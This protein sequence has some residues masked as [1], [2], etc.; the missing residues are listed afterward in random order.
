MSDVNNALQQNTI[1][2]RMGEETGIVIEKTKEQF[3]QSLF[4]EHYVKAIQ[5][6]NDIIG[7]KEQIASSNIIAFCADRG[8]GKTSCME[9]V[10]ELLTIKDRFEQFEEKFAENNSHTNIHPDKLLR[11]PVIDPAYFDEKHNIIELITGMMYESLCKRKDENTIFD[12]TLLVAKF[13]EVQKALEYIEKASSTES[14]I[15]DPLDKVQSLSQGLKLPKLISDLMEMYLKFMDKELLVICID[16]IDLNIQYAYRMIEQIRKYLSNRQCLILFASNIEQLTLVVRHSIEMDLYGRIIEGENS[17]SQEMA[18]KYVTKLLPT[19]QRINLVHIVDLY[20][21][22]LVLLNNKGEEYGYWDKVKEAISQ[23][24]YAKTRYL[25]YNNESETSPIIPKNLR[26]FRHLMSL[27]TSMPDYN[28]AQIRREIAIPTSTQLKDDEEGK[29]NKSAFKNYFYQDW[30]ANNLTMRDMDFA[31]SLVEYTDISGINLYVVQY[32]SS[33][34]K[35]GN[36]GKIVTSIET[37][38]NTRLMISRE[39]LKLILELTD[40]EQQENEMEERLEQ[41]VMPLIQAIVD[42]QNKSYN[43]TLGDVFYLLDYLQRGSTSIG[44]KMLLFFIKSFYSMQLYEKYDIITEQKGTLYPIR[45]TSESRVNIYRVDDTYQNTN[46][47]QR[48]VNGSFFTY[49]PN[50]FMAFDLSKKMPRDLRLIKAKMVKDLFREVLIKF[51]EDFNKVTPMMKLKFQMCEFL[52]WTISR[53]SYAPQGSDYINAALLDRKQNTPAF[54]G[55]FR[56]KTTLYIFDICAP[57]YNALNIRYAYNRIK[58][59]NGHDFYELA[60]KYPDSLL[61][62]AIRA[63]IVDRTNQWAKKDQDA[64]E[65]EKTKSIEEAKVRALTK[66]DYYSMLSSA[67]I[68]NADV[69]ISLRDHIISKKNDVSKEGANTLQLLRLFYNEIINSEMYTYQQTDENTNYEIRFSFLGALVA[70]LNDLI[71]VNDKYISEDHEGI[72]KW[73]SD[74]LFAYPKKT[75]KKGQKKG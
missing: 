48:F 53:T 74:V 61:N 10:A 46:V 18:A 12:T 52:C 34:F 72:A 13:R 67:I 43:I 70:F 30:I 8:E 33:R 64:S 29:R 15:Y 27:L 75:S 65:E 17:E 42:N 31:I 37:S 7:R 32:L 5:I 14:P 63:T 9:T 11:L 40:E 2:F 23:L 41:N 6:A 58:V 39:D 35:L 26:S 56:P 57:F 51:P 22:P 38:K 62:Q 45:D 1:I 59:V 16:D 19:S 4:R 47:L 21:R 50:E 3:E 66:F 69:L 28:N 44:D 60:K 68:R 20:D 55:A 24:I 71:P 49:L 36:L 73:L 25:F 54:Y